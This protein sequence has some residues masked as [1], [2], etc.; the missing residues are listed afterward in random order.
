MSDPAT[1]PLETILKQCAAHA[2]QP[3]YPKAD[4]R[5]IPRDELDVLL[6]ELRLAGLIRLTDWV[7]GKGQGYALTPAGTEALNSSAVLAR[8][9]RGEV[10]APRPAP[11]EEPPERAS[12]TFRR[13]EA[14]RKAIESH[15]RPVVT[16][17]LLYANIAVFVVGCVLSVQRL[18]SANPFLTGDPAAGEILHDTGLILS[19]DVFPG[20]QWWRLLA[21]AFVHIGL[22]HLLANMVTLWMVGPLL[23]RL[24]GRWNYLA[25]YLVSALCA[26]CTMV[27]YGRGGAGASGALWGVVASL[28]VWFFLNRRALNPAAFRAQVSQLLFVLIIN[29]VITFSVPNI[30]IEGHFGGGLAGLLAAFAVDYARYHAGWRRT[31][32]YAALPLLFVAY[33]SFFLQMYAAPHFLPLIESADEVAR[34]TWVNGDLK[35]LV[36]TPPAER[37]IDPQMQAKLDDARQRLRAVDRKRWVR[38]FVQPDRR[39][40]VDLGIEVLD[41]W[42]G[43][44]DRVSRFAKAPSD[45]TQAEEDDLVA[46]RDSLIQTRNRWRDLLS[47]PKKAGE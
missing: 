29:V 3:W 30:S 20:G 32:A 47:P 35:T 9:R 26:S 45:W 1:H 8:L 42:I 38:F 33:L 5:H 7:Q 44:F 41:A 12:L 13:V 10:P 46:H 6:D 43:L 25:I 21:C 36:R 40:K 23:E 17:S 2:P 24:W 11:K 22:L 4:A 27:A 39:G 28:G 14:V 34:Q 31:L 16:L 15:D 18:G 37:R 19:Q